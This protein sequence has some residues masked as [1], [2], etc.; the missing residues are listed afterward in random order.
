MSPD[1]A[2]PLPEQWSADDLV[3]A[4]LAGQYD[5]ISAAF[6]AGLLNDVVRSGAASQGSDA[7]RPSQPMDHATAAK[8]NN[9]QENR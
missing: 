8:I 9:A 1:N 5:R 4:R 2:G 3:A 6:D 7:P